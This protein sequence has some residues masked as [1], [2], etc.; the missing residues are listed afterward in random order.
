MATNKNQDHFG[1]GTYRASRRRRFARHL[2]DKKYPVHALV[3]NTADAGVRKLIGHGIELVQ[4][5]L[6]DQG[7]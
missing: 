4:G 2:R 1:H 7:S 5:N 6:D 3:R